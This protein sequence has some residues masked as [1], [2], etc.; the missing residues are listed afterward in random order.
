M[1]KPFRRAVVAAGLNPKEI[2]PHIMRHTAITRLVKAGVDLATIQRISGHKT[3]SM[4]L[5]YTHVHE[6]HIDKA[7]EAIGT[8]FPEPSTNKMPDTITHKLH[9][10]P[11]GK[12]D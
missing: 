3:L 4:V 11:G 2:T 8:S 6:P 5:R 10:V 9:T 12:S 7:I 1:D